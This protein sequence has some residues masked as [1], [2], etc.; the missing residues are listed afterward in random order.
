ME[1]RQEASPLAGSRALAEAFMEVAEAS[2]EEAAST[3]A[4]AVGDNSV[5]L[6]QTRLMIRRKNPCAQII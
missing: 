4:A 1:E 3:E 2:T 6:P 5:Q